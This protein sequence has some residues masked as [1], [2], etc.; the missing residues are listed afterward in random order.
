MCPRL[1][2]RLPGCNLWLALLPLHGLLQS[3]WKCKMVQKPGCCK[4]C[5]YFFILIFFVFFYMKALIPQSW[6]WQAAK[7]EP[8]GASGWPPEIAKQRCLTCAALMQSR[9]LGVK[10]VRLW[11]KE[12]MCRR[13]DKTEHQ[14]FWSQLGSGASLVQLVG[15]GGIAPGRQPLESESCV[16]LQE[17]PL[18]GC[19]F[20]A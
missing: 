8:A 14:A 5:F 11:W 13:H 7:P 16:L 12:F 2:P 10:R 17:S 4:K 3:E 15:R 9:E 18:L 6:L 20:P 19:S 1:F